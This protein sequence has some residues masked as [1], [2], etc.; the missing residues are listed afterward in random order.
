MVL[1]NAPYPDIAT[2]FPSIEVSKDSTK[3]ILEDNIKQ[4]EN[5][6]AAQ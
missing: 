2:E 6:E 5:E 4:D 3:P 1:E